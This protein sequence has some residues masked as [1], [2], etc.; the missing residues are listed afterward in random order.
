MGAAEACRRGQGAGVEPCW[1]GL[2]SSFCSVLFS[3]A[4]RC[5]SCL[6]VWKTGF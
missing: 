6:M 3:S 4:S 2:T 1:E 5:C